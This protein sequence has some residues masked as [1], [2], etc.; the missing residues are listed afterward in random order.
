M[1]RTIIQTADPK[2][3]AE[4]PIPVGL[5]NRV[6][7]A[8]EMVEAALHKLGKKFDIEAGWQFDH[9]AGGSFAVALS[10]G[11]PAGGHID[12]SFSDGELDTDEN[13]RHSLRSP[14][15][16]VADILSEELDR[17]FERIRRGLQLLAAE[18]GE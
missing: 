9:R 7:R 10:L 13:I 8:A 4:L 18:G 11:S 5:L 12:H 6:R 3:G 1:L 2:T 14:L 15:W 17:D 16:R